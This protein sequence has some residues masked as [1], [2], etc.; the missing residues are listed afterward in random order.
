MLS[1]Y[2]YCITETYQVVMKCWDH[3]DL[4]VLVRCWQ[5]TQSYKGNFQ[6]VKNFCFK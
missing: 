4:S 3:Q 1:V 5:I 2:I 6:K